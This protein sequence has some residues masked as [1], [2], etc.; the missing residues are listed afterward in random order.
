[1]NTEKKTERT[2]APVK[3][4]ETNRRF[5]CQ[6]P[7]RH[8]IR[9]YPWFQLK[10]DLQNGINSSA[11]RFCKSVQNRISPSMI[12]IR[13]HAGTQAAD[14]YAEITAISFSLN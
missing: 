6:P 8:H 14:D 10:Q 1:M 4:D 12:F 11:L 9:V 5:I 13:F 3:A 7:F 2:F